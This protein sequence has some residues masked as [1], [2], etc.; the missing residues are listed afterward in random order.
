MNNSLNPDIEEIAVA[1][2]R[3]SRIDGEIGEL[4]IRGFPID[5]L[6]I[7]ATYEETVF[8]LVNGRLPTTDKLAEFRAELSTHREISEEIRAVLQRAA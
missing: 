1:E 3:R 7:N 2:T 5:E 8:L 4:V 6:A